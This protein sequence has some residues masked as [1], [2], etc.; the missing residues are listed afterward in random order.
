MADSDE[1]TGFKVV[2]KRKVTMD[3][4]GEVHA[5]P[6]TETSKEVGE[7]TPAEPVEVPTIDVYSLL[8]YFMG[9]LGGQAWQWLGLAKNPLS[10]KV[11]KDLVQAKIAIDSM[12]ALAGFLSSEL[13]PEEQAD[14]DRLMSNLRINYVQQSAKSS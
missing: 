5:K 8:A 1:E 10:G 6:E 11:E 13:G 2:D 7:A 12:A 3:E 9:V 14:L 4:S